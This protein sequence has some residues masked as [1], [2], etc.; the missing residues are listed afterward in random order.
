MT[1]TATVRLPGRFGVWS[2]AF[3]NSDTGLVRDVA[4][5]LDELGYGVLWFPG[6]VSRTFSVAATL[7]EGTR[8]SMVATGIVNIWVNE[9]AEASQQTTGLN[10]RHDN[11]FLLGLGVSH[12]PMVDRLRPAAWRSPLGAMTDYL[13]ELERIRPTV[14]QASRLLAALGP[15]MIELARSRTA[16]THPYLITP[17]Q[18]AI[19]R[20]QIG[21]TALV[22]VEQGVVLDPDP[23]SARA[24]VRAALAMYLGLPNYVNS[25]KRAG[26]TDDD[27]PDGGSDRLIDALV[28]HGSPDDVAARVRE[29]LGAGADHVCLQVL[30]EPGAVPRQA[31]RV[32]ASALG[33]GA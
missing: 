4:A 6:G 14:P 27:L 29:H 8:R 30:G 5:E 20:G 11:R 17:D 10:A 31:W 21:P 32:L 12:Q 15:K 26:F 22:A 25:W 9:P 2:G 33:L 13:D 19:I 28:A 7:L 18:T 1:E 16:G 3:R 23:S 24:T